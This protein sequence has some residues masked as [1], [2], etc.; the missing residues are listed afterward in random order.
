MMMM[1]DDDDDDDDTRGF[2]IQRS[3]VVDKV[4]MLVGASWIAL[5]A[6]ID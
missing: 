3:S 6:P 2:I 4:L 5:H 1:Y